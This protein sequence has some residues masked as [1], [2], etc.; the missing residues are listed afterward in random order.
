M[1]KADRIKTLLDFWFGNRL[2]RDLPNQARTDFWFAGD[3]QTDALIKSEF[4]ADL[5]NAISGKYDSWEQDPRG[6]LALILLFDQFPRNLFRGTERA[7]LFDV[8]ALDLAQQGIEN[9]HDHQLTLIERVF[10]Y[11]PLEHTEDL[12]VQERSVVAFESL[13]AVSL[14]EARAIYERFL[15]HAYEHYDVIKKFGRFPYRNAHLNRE[16]TADELTYLNGISRS[17]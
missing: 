9:E 1:Y 8:K 16:S 3:S 10:F 5:E 7:Y 14:P 2:E 4:E 15:H 6:R 11:L 12:S 17:H 13:L